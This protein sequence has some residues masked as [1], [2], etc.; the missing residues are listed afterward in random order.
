MDTMTRLTVFFD[1]PF[2]IG[3]FE[4]TENGRLSVCKVTFGAEPKDIEVLNYIRKNY[5][6]LKFSP[7]VE[8]AVKKDSTNPK[9]KQRQAKKLTA[10]TESER[11]VSRLYSFSERKTNLN[12]K[13]SA[14]NS[15]MPKK[16][17]GLS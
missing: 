1:D 12:A 6:R 15:V 14:S 10:Q 4:R 7:S 13:L 16:N 11:K 17:G 5:C 2:W 9:R 8:T 3:V